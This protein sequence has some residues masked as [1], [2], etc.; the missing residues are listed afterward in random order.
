MVEQVEI[1]SLDL[2]FEGYRLKSKAAERVLLASISENG[3]RDPLRGVDAKD[4]RILL[5]GFK[6][7]RC[8]KKLGIAIVPYCSLAEDVGVAIVELLRISNAGSLGILE[9]ARLIDELKSVYQMS[10]KDIAQYLEKSKSWVSVRSGIARE[11]S[12]VV[13]NR[14]FKGQFP[15]YAYMYVLRPFIRINKIKGEEI[16]EFVNLV[17]GKGLS[18]RDIERLAHGY[19]KGSDEFRRQIKDGNILRGLNSLKETSEKASECTTI[20]Q[21]MIKDLELV[22]KYMQRV[23]FKS[24]ETRYKTDAF[25]AQANLLSGGISRLIDMFAKAVRDVHDRSGKT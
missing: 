16:D 6:R 4:A 23:T 21:A 17:A 11:I 24:N 25:F 19:F 20:E 12:Q 9:Q 14:I 8:A 18:I 7:Y 1:S 3:I 15:V 5:D 10:T 13:M 22:Q 2:R